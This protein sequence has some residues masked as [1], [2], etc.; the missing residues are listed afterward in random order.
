MTSK[1][2]IRALLFNN[3][4]SRLLTATGAEPLSLA[5]E[6]SEAP[7]ISIREWSLLGD[8]VAAPL[9]GHEASVTALVT[10]GETLA[11]GGAD[12]VVRLWKMNAPA[13]KTR[14]V[15]TMKGHTGT[16]SS[17]A[18]LP[19]GRVLSGGND[20]TI[21]VWGST[22]R[23]LQ[24][25][26]RGHVGGVLGLLPVSDAEFVSL[27]AD[28]TVRHIPGPVSRVR[29]SRFPRQRIHGGHSTRAS[30]RPILPLRP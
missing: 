27:G 11:S 6:P 23:L 7:E 21:R 25:P 17:L 8:E 26:F 28:Q 2:S 22:G 18:F 13:T 12:G 4:G 29:A 9:F 24:G 14:L 16:V 10:D 5:S 30:C 3:D 15:A 1:G 20:G 19:D